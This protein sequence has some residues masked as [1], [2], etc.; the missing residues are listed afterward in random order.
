[1][2]GITQLVSLPLTPRPI[3]EQRKLSGQYVFARK[4]IQGTWYSDSKAIL[5][6]SCR[7]TNEQTAYQTGQYLLELIYSICKKQTNTTGTVSTEAYP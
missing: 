7:I 2:R 1:M 5:C 3:A 4:N 6:I